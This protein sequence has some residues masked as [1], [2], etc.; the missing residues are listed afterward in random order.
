MIFLN[1][2]EVYEALSRKVPE[3]VDE[4]IWN[5]LAKT[6]RV[7]W[8]LGG[9]PG[10]TLGEFVEEYRELELLSAEIAQEVKRP[11]RKRPAVR[12]IPPDERLK[13][14]SREQPGMQP[15]EMM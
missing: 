3:G 12:E 15:N 11:P 8:L 6:D 4:A 2:H 14:L 9:E 10:Y 5:H 13:A 1:E 7:D